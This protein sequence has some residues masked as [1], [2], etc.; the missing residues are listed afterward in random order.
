MNLL[1][2]RLTPCFRDT[3]RTCCVDTGPAKEPGVAQGCAG[4]NSALQKIRESLRSLQRLRYD[5][6][7]RPHDFGK[8]ADDQVDGNLQ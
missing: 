1:T 7:E 3:S 8:L 5:R 2:R 6:S 4:T